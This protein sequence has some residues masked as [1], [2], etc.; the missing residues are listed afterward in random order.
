MPAGA[1]EDSPRPAISRFP[2]VSM[3]LF[4][5]DEGSLLADTLLDRTP[6]RR[7]AGAGGENAQRRAMDVAI[8]TLGLGACAVVF[9]ALPFLVGLPT[10]QAFWTM[11]FAE[12]LANGPVWGLRAR[13]FGVPEPAP[14]AFGLPGALSAS[15]FLRLGV[16]APDAYTLMMLGWLAVAYW[17]AYR[18]AVLLGVPSRV[19]VLAAVTWLCTPIVWGHAHYSQLA[20]GIALLPLYFLPTLLVITRDPG[21]GLGP[22]RLLG[23]YVAA[24]VT[25]LFMDG[26]SFVMLAL[27]TVLTLVYVAARDRERRSAIVRRALPAF[28]LSAVIAYVLYGAYLG[29]SH[30]ENERLDLFRSLGVAVAYVVVPTTGMHWIPDA[31]G[32]ST[33]RAESEHWGDF[34]V[35]TTTFALP[36]L[37]LGSAAWWRTRRGTVLATGFLLIAGF[38]LYMSLGPSVKI[39][40]EVPDG[41]PNR[42]LL[43]G[44]GM[45]PSGTGPI[46]AHLPGFD[47]MRASYRWLALC[48]FFLWLLLVLYARNQGAASCSNRARKH[49][50]RGGVVALAVVTALNVPHIPDKLHVN[51][52]FRSSFQQADRELV[53]LL[54]DHVAPGEVAAFLP[55]GNDFMV[56][57]LAPRAGFRAFNIGGDKNLY[58]AIRHWPAEMR[59][60]RAAVGTGRPDGIVALLENGGADVVVLPYISMLRATWA[61]PCGI[62]HVTRDS[63]R[64][65]AAPDSG[66]SCIDGGRSSLEPLLTALRG[67][68]DVIVR[69]TPL[70][71]SVRTSGHTAGEAS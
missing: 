26:Y 32:L 21:S 29:E 50:S 37:V 39:L 34:S 68:S 55:W 62:H 48:V 45:L 64:G 24:A 59:P 7:P 17:G 53:P 19:A 35:F 11:G 43:D 65:M 16:P 46:S 66:R 13:D 28:L 31:L 67:R 57:Y 38:A 20:L 41:T 63:H 56:N 14:M 58:K 8:W 33:H 52:E 25:A 49:M 70:F 54:R 18:V 60:A 3:A 2:N 4:A 42:Y 5:V 22:A 47:V 27:A 10:W 44:V 36:L 51:R 30:F 61:W 15:M 12:S 69:Q 6:L 1:G 40:G 71:A 23:S 9:G